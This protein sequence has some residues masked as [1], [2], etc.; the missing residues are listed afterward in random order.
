MKSDHLSVLEIGVGFISMLIPSMM[1]GRFFYAQI[2]L[3]DKKM[4]NVILQEK[5]LSR[6]EASKFLGVCK[7]TLDRMD[8]PRIRVRRRVLYQQ[9]ALITW[10]KKNTTGKEARP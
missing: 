10:L 7:T 3:E 1:G 4:N 8:L 2:F 6:E 5:V 9:T